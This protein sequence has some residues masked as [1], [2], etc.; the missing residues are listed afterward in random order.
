MISPHEIHR[1]IAAV[2]KGDRRAFAELYRLSSPKLY[3]VILRI[4]RRRE[5]AAQA[6]RLAYARI[7][8]QASHYDGSEEPVCWLVGIAR[9]S[10]L[11][12]ARESEVP[13]AFEPFEVAVPARDPLARQQRS[14]ALRRLLGCLGALS[15]ERRRMVLL[16]F[17]D[18]CSRH[19]LSIY[20]DAPVASIRAWIARS[21]S[22][23]AGCLARRP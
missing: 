23:I 10:A 11:D 7:A 17:Y 3:G 12:I 22:E 18:G 21:T 6:M 14:L 20:F 9:A 4:L 16:A 15:V 13:D 8:T 5:R 19:A 1:L 2:A